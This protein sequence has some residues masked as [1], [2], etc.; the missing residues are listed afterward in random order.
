MLSSCCLRHE[1]ELIRADKCDSDSEFPFASDFL[2]EVNRSWTLI[3]IIN[4][5]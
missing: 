4:E 2:A 5:Y 3:K 1:R